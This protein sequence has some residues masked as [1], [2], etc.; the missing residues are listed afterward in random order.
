MSKIHK[1]FCPNC[2]NYLGD[3]QCGTPYCNKCKTHIVI[4]QGKDVKRVD[5]DFYNGTELKDV[6]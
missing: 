4:K 3:I 2:N 6:I 1:T 5:K